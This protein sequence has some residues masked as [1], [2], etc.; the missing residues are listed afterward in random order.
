MRFNGEVFFI[1]FAVVSI[2][3]RRAFTAAIPMN[4]ATL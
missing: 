2:P 3:A 4:L 1:C